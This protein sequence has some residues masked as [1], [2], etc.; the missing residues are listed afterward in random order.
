[1]TRDAE[2]NRPTAWIVFVFSMCVVLASFTSVIFPSLISVSETVQIPGIV[3]VTPDPYE[4]GPWAGGVIASCA[5]MCVLLLLHRRGTLPSAISAGLNRLLAFEVPKRAALV[6][7]TVLIVSYVAVS[8]G[9]LNTEEPYEDYIDVKER[10]ET[11]SADQALGSFEPHLRYLLLASSMEIF[12]SYKVI[13]LLA[14]AALLLVTY[15]LTSRITGKRFAGIVSII[16]LM[17]SSVF[18]TY[19]TT[20][21]YTNFWVLLYVASLYMALRFWP[22]SPVLYL[23]SLPAKALT[24]AFL[25][26]SLY[27]IWQGDTTQKHRIITVSVTAAMIV[28]VGA[29]AATGIDPTSGGEAAIEGFNKKEFMAGLAS[30]SYQLRFDGLVMLFCIP[31]IVGLF[32]ASRHGARHAMPVMLL[33]AGMLLIAPLL[34]GFTNQTN[35]PYRFVPLVVFFAIGVGVLLSGVLT[36]GK[37]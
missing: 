5:V 11:W 24:V 33:I 22:L 2:P 8:A 16:V 9:E 6:I 15:M 27:F 28:I 7:V 18:L 13:P 1:M 32:L 25:P 3:P 20:V 17:Q 26:M 21:A 30:F 12:G 37:P 10:L 31:L 29:V 19:D 34:T 4:T 35:Q 14:S 36:K 23:A